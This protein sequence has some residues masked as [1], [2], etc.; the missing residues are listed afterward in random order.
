MVSAIRFL[1]LAFFSV[2]FLASGAA[3]DSN[4]IV[5]DLHPD[6]R[7][8]CLSCNCEILFD[9]TKGLTINDILSAEYANKFIENE[10][11][12]IQAGHTRAAVWIRFK[13]K[14]SSRPSGAGPG[15][16]ILEP[17]KPNIDKIDLYL[18]DINAL[19]RYRAIET[20]DLR[21]VENK[22]F[23]HRSYAFRTPVYN[24]THTYYLRLESYTALGIGIKLWSPE[25]FHQKS[26]VE[27]FGF[28]AIYGSLVGIILYNFFVFLSL[29]DKAY[30]Y[31]VLF[32]TSTLAYLMLVNG[33]A[34]WLFDLSPGRGTIYIWL[35]LGAMGFAGSVFTRIFLSTRENTPILD[36]A[37]LFMMVLSVILAVLG[38]LGLN[39]TARH[40]GHFIGLVIP[41]IGVV[42]GTGCLFKGYRPAMFF[43]LAWA[44]FLLGVFLF[45]LGGTIIPRSIFTT[46]PLPISSAIQ[47]ILLSFALA[48]RIRVLQQEKE[49]LKESEKR[50][51]QLSITDGLTGLYNNRYFHSKL[52][53]EIQHAQSLDRPLSLLMLDIDKFKDIN[54]VYGHPEGDKVLEGL[55][56]IIVDSVR[57]IDIPC[58]YGG[59]EFA[60]I[61]PETIR[62][63]ALLIAERIRNQFGDI[64]FETHSEAEFSATVSLGAAMLNP[65]E[66]GNSLISRADKALYQ[67]KREGRNRTVAAPGQD[68][69]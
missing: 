47:A 42:T 1:L 25:N 35:M 15:I 52:A 50:Y 68:E 58:R 14:D 65:L 66:D 20:G 16:W 32:V 9:P 43:L 11:D 34:A 8:A 5:L 53:G 30:F 4:S 56:G 22:P 48:Y 62:E 46:A 59:E 13:L 63:Q 37:I 67:A 18:P 3:A 21:P 57:D 44:S 61:L 29:R 36:K 54:D 2:L 7:E 31:Y 45:S 26:T 38:L 64:V 10:G 28:G 39:N 41:V 69:K 12:A 24:K 23:R 33:Q 51:Q 27:S 55:A 40:L 6:R 19:N 17:A 49:D 60:I